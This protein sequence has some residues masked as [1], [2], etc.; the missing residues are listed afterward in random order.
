[1]IYHGSRQKYQDI[2]ITTT[3]KQHKPVE[4]LTNYKS[5]DEFR[6]GDVCLV[7]NVKYCRLILKHGWFCCS[8]VY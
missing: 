2:A 5:Q 6:L 8:V 3:G 7:N 1:M 4:I